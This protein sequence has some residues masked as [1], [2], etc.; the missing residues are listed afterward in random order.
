MFPPSFLVSMFLTLSNSN[1]LQVTCVLPVSSQNQ[2]G[3]MN[4]H[5]IPFPSHLLAHFR[6]LLKHLVEKSC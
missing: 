3:M 1:I 2:K 6:V 5:V 4:L